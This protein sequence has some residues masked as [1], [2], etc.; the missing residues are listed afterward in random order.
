MKYTLVVSLFFTFFLGHSQEP[1]KSTIEFSFG[2]AKNGTGDINGFLYGAQYQ[3]SF[4]KKVYWVVGFEG[5]FHDNPLG[6]Q[7]FFELDGEKF[8]STIRFVTAGMQLATGIKYNFSEND[9]ST[10]GI[11]VLPIL[12][13][14]STS[15]NDIIST[16]YPIGTGLPIPVRI[17]INE[18]P[19]RTLSFG[20]ALRLNYNYIFNKG[21]YLGILA[22]FQ[23]DTNGD[24]MINAGL[25][26][27]KRFNF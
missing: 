24:S 27:G 17:L 7:L 15:I 11:Y 20:G 9:K 4:S 26:F 23:T 21:L 1:N 3:Q 13:Y 25:T 14:Q 5:T 19:S 12:R 6:D 18:E 10:F 22:G 2:W 16:E 8:D